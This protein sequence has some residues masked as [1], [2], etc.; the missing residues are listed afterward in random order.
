MNKSNDDYKYYFPEFYRKT[1]DNWY[2]NYNQDE[3]RVRYM[4][5]LSDGTFRI[6]C[7]GADDESLEFDFKSE[8]EAQVEFNY[9]SGLLVINKDML[10]NR[11]YHR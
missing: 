10:L 6:I 1:D 9:L 3:V 7:E 11:G 5:Q 8:I 4:G 2:P